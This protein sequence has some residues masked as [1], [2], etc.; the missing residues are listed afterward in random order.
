[1]GGVGSTDERCGVSFLRGPRLGDSPTLNVLRSLSVLAGS[2]SAAQGRRSP[3]NGRTE[4]Q[5]HGRVNEALVAPA[6]FPSVHVIA[7]QHR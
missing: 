5:P 6:P 2:A 7:R 4:P 1:M 3:E